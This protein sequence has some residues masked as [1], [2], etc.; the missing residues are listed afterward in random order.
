MGLSDKEMRKQGDRENAMARAD[1][2]N[3]AR[4]WRNRHVHGL[5]LMHAD[6]RTQEYAPHRHE[7]LVVAATELGGSV[8]KSRGVTEQASRSALFVFNP[9]EPHSG[10]MGASRHWRYRALYLEQQ[11]I[12]EVAS[13]IGFDHVPY[14]TR[15]DF[16]DPDLVSGFLALHRALAEGRDDLHQR[17]LLV[18]TFGTLFLRHGSGRP[19]LEPAPRDRLRLRRAVELVQSRLPQ[20]ISLASLSASLG[21][22]QYQLISLF[23]RTTG[24]T[25]H[26]YVTQLRLDLACRH[27]TAGMA[28]ADAALAAGFYD[29]SALTRHFKRCYGVTP[30]QFALAVRG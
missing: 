18:A 6:F 4:Y 16:A 23:K 22:T 24:L 5:D 10:W 29:Q 12:D 26:A 17:E 21:L 1:P 2:L 3:I 20:D 14:F 25:P 11:A 8:V 30:R 28:I 19:R 7:A 13:G 15:N 9:D 27:L